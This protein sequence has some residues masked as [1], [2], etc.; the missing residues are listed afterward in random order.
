MENFTPRVMRGWGLDY[1]NLR[2]L[3]PDIIHVSNTGYGHGD[4]PYSGYP[5]QAT[6]QEATHGPLLGYRLP[7]RRSGQ[8]G[9][10]F[11]GLPLHLERHL[12]LGGRPALPQSHRQGPVGSTSPCTRQ[13]SCSCLS[14][15]WMPPS[16]EGREGASATATP[17]ARRRAA[18]RHQA[19]T[20]GLLSRWAV[21]E[22]W[23]S[24]CG[25]MGKDELV[26]D[27]RFADILSRRKQPR[28]Y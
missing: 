13:G 28:R 23:Q 7:E 27:A 15:L 3:K 19:M 24:L 11:R 8:G 4:G 10:L 16:T 17:S 2:K 9:R 21:D 5:A 26:G 1:P 6:T 25:L 12:C 18:I 20:S 22:E 14:T